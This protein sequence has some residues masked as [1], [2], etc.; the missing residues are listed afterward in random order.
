MHVPRHDDMD[1]LMLRTKRQS[2]MRGLDLARDGWL[3]AAAIPGS[4]AAVVTERYDL[5]RIVIDRDRYDR[6]VAGTDARESA[7]HDVPGPNDTS[8]VAGY[9]MTPVGRD[10]D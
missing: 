1:D 3:F 6:T 10:G 8:G 7:S 4:A 9:Y 5:A 2:G